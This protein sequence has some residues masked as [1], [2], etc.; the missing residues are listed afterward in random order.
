MTNKELLIYLSGLFDGEGNISIGKAHKN[1]KGA[2]TRY[3]QLQV[4]IG[5]QHKAAIDLFQKTFGGST[6][7]NSSSVWRITW[8]CHKAGEVLKQL[9]PFL[10]VKR[11]Q[12]IVALYFQSLLYNPGRKGYTLEETQRCARLHSIV[13]YLNKRD[14]KSFRKISKQQI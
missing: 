6:V 13:S 7:L 5:M 9:V 12:A 3:Y 4:Q 11:S 8:S 1:K 10:L 2:K 14:S